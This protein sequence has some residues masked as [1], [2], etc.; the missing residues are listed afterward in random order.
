V[1][2]ADNLATFICRLPENPEPQPPEGLGAYL[3]VYKD[4][5]VSFL[6]AF[7]KL[8]KVTIRI[9]IIKCTMTGP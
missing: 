9:T 7:T 4:S 3:D 2:K 5:F 6:D 1:C 8:R